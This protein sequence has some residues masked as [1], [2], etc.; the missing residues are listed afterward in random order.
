LPP[1]S[2]PFTK[3]PRVP[4]PKTPVTMDNTVALSEK[5]LAHIRDEK[6]D[7][8]E[9]ERQLQ[10][11]E[12][13]DS[14]IE[15]VRVTVPNTDDPQLPCNTFRMWFLGLLF[16]LI[17]SFVNQFF[18]LRQT[19]I[20]I[21]YSVVAL[22]SLPL[23]H[24]M[25]RVLPTRKFSL[26]GFSF[27]LN[28]GPFSIKEHVL[29]GTMTSCNTYSAYAVDIVV[30]QN[31]FYHDEKPFIAGLLLVLTTQV[32]GF[33]LAGALRRFLYVHWPVLLAATSNMPPGQ[34]YMYTN[35]L[36]IGFI[37]AFL[38]RRYRYNW[39]SRYNYLT[40]AALDSGLAVAGLVIFFCIQSWGGK[41]PYWWGNP[42]PENPDPVAATVDHCPLGAKNYYGW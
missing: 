41:F 32:T 42:D 35:G 5:D 11:Q 13:E 2:Q 23:G 38:L 3:Y 39:W 1:I 27:S 26:F 36:F 16:T 31:I 19:T 6:M 34:P 18:H 4:I 12:E 9:L 20:T 28:P 33:A 24:A 40:S 8:S 14:P 29:I 30:L 10:L 22:V 21:G 7:A 17:I 37:F 15:E 25:A